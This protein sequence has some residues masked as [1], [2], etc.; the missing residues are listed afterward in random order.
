MT[1]ETR[2]YLLAIGSYASSAVGTLSCKWLINY[3]SAVTTAIMWYVGGTLVTFFM[4][5]AFQGGISWR[6]LR[7]NSKV[8]L[9]VSLIMSAA[10]LAWFVSI[11][12][13]GPSIV[14]F[15]QQLGV[16]F[17]VLLGAF[18]LH[19]RLGRVEAIGGAIAITGALVISYRAGARVELGVVFV[20]VN[21][22]GVAIQNLLVKQHVKEIDKLE[23][24]FVRSVVALITLSVYSTVGGGLAMPKTWLLPGFLIASFVGYVVV[25]LLLYQ[26]LSHVDLSKVSILAV[27]TAPMVMVASIFLFN[28][29]PTPL[30]LVGSG[31]I[32]AGT[33]L[34]IA[35]PMLAHRARVVE[36]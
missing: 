14:A 23:L 18:V 35:Q 7:A 3:T 13:A 16:V 33:V 21:S 15:V 30:Q 5:V 11:D 22:L 9:Q 34:I 2:G 32:L 28:S 19:E 20:L 12:L 17:G 6:S 4:L 26:A 24:V 1:R 36:A 29:I 27:T 25:N 8:Y 10:A 31:L